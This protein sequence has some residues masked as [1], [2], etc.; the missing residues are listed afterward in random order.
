MYPVEK[1]QKMPVSKG[2]KRPAI[3]LTPQNYSEI[4]RSATR[5]E[6]PSKTP[7]LIAISTSLLLDL[8]SL[9]PKN[10]SL[11]CVFK[12]PVNFDVQ[13]TKTYESPVTVGLFTHTHS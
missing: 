6:N 11:L 2:Q 10:F 7:S 5:T 12:F 3:F 4:A 8:I 9:F 13:M 1:T